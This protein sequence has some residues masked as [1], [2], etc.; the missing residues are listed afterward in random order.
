MLLA[1][2]CL[3]TGFALFKKAPLTHLVA[4]LLVAV[5][6]SVGMGILTGPLLVGY[7]WLVERERK[8]ET[9]SPTDVFKGFDAF[10]PA[11]IVSLLGG[12][13]VSIGYALMVIPGLLLSPLVPLGL[14]LVAQG[15]R[16]GV[17]ALKDAW[18]ILK[19]HLLEALLCSLALAFVAGLGAILCGVGVFLTL[20]IASIG[21]VC[22]AK[23][24]A[25]G[26]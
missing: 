24:L 22:M 14:W 7:A 10:V 4:L 12:L 8:G 17:G 5:G 20:P 9:T 18:G 21:S 13:I 11:L 3:S 6:G 26:A 15:E 1:Q 25:A 2:E 23:R 16:D 19:N